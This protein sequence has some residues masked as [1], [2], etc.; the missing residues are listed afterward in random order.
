MNC[1]DFLNN[2]LFILWMISPTKELDAYWKKYLDSEEAS[3]EAFNEAIEEFNTI[4]SFNRD[5]YNT[6][7]KI[8]KLRLDK[9][10]ANFKK[11]KRAMF[12]IFTSVA[13]ALLLIISMPLITKNFNGNNA[14]QEVIIGSNTNND[15]IQLLSGDEVL[16]IGNNST[17]DL[18]EKN[19]NV[20]IHDSTSKK[21]IKLNDIKTNKLI[22]PYG[23]RSSIVLADGSTVYL[24]SGS[25]LTFPASFNGNTR[26]INAVGEIYIEVAKQKEPFI[27]HTPKSN[28]RVYGTTFNVSAYAEE[29]EESVVL[30]NGSV[31][32][33]SNNQSLML[34]PNERAVVKNGEIS[35]KTVD[36]SEYV[37]WKNGFFKL[38][39][40]P[41]N[42]VL[43]KI[44]RYYN[45]E[46][47]YSKDLMLEAKTCSGKLF[48]ADNINDVL[49]SFSLMTNLMYR[50]D[51]DNRITISK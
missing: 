23:K 47:I 11:K 37:S 6:E 21:E 36:I 41:L 3:I 49:K 12:T 42:D 15:G 31:Q 50:I 27:I 19:N 30:V 1:N 48:L 7:E 14:H 51:S 9:N 20:I 43:M 17:L 39:N 38:Y 22:V 8:V 26:E 46:F 5:S 33:E 2:D 35:T 24:N 25:E 45:V 44:G 10:I 34:K 32:I 18:T 4:R 40:S 29:I 13:A 16:S 28:I